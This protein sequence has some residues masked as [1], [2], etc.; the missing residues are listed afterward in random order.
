[1]LEYYSQQSK[2]VP[3]RIE[4]VLFLNIL[5]KPVGRFDNLQAGWP[6]FNS[7]DEVVKWFVRKQNEKFNVPAVYEMVKMR[8]V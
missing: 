8:F 3:T 4:C 6:F 2:I 7:E 5:K 1:V